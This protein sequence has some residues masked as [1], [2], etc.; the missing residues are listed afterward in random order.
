MSHLPGGDLPNLPNLL[1]SPVLEPFRLSNWA[2]TFSFWKG[3]K[4][5]E[6]QETGRQGSQMW[7][8][9]LKLC[10]HG[11][12]PILLYPGPLLT[13]GHPPEELQHKSTGSVSSRCWESSSRF[14]IQTPAANRQLQPGFPRATSSFLT[15]MQHHKMLPFPAWHRLWILPSL[16]SFP[17]RP[18]PSDLSRVP[19]SPAPTS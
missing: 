6:E 7:L 15:F 8:G 4:H 1:S 5:T 9:L 19:R 12:H 18:L 2:S 11:S 13:W 3:G 14:Y 17:H 10:T 16:L